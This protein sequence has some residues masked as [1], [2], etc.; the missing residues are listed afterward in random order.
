MKKAT[1]RESVLPKSVPFPTGP[2]RVIEVDDLLGSESEYGHWD[3]ESRTIKVDGSMSDDVKFVTLYHEMAHAILDEYAVRLPPKKEEA[4]C[5]AFGK[6]L[7]FY[8]H[9]S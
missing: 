4:V 2:Y 6:Y 5:E 1:K 9:Q 8:L 7:F 3:Y